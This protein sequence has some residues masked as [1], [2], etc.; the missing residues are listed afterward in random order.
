MPVQG[1]KDQATALCSIID[2]VILRLMSNFASD[3]IPVFILN[4]FK[5]KEGDA[6]KKYVLSF[7]QMQAL[8]SLSSV[9]SFPEKTKGKETQTKSLDH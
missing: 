9:L 3:V 5:T 6:T 8:A 7:K 4:E 2:L 1:P